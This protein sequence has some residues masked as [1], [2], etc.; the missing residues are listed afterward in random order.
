MVTRR[1][2]TSVFYSALFILLM[3]PALSFAD[4]TTTI[5]LTNLAGAARGEE[6]IPAVT[7]ASTAEITFRSTG[8]SNVKAQLSLE[9]G[10]ADSALLDISR[11]FIKAR[12][13]AFRLTLGK[14]R[15]SWGEGFM[16]NAGDVLFDSLSAAVDL[17]GDEIRT[18]GSW[19]A[20]VYLPLGRFSFL[21]TVLL[22][23]VFDPLEYLID[24]R[25]AAETGSDMP[26]I[27][28][29]Y[30]TSAGARL[31]LRPGGIKTETGY[32]YSGRTESHRPYASLQGH[33]LADW[34]LSASTDMSIYEAGTDGADNLAVSFG[35]FHS[36][37]TSPAA[38]LNLRLEGAV[39]PLADEKN[40]LL[41]PEISF[42][43]D[44]R[45]T[46]FL[47]NI[48]SIDDTSSVHIAGMTWNIYQGFKILAYGGICSGENGDTFSWDSTLSTSAVPGYFVSAGCSFVF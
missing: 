46:I 6:N 35:L 45:R 20:S 36:V 43:P 34:N 41:Y 3:L 29:G 4:S 11:A 47:R 17:T 37:K 2:N 24:S 44:D 12:F 31:V 8:N 19:L 9:A 42:S 5:E 38:A 22:P 32:L 40:L 39:N 18:D 1:E 21:E 16:F 25:V 28:G 15:L 26:E 14:T 30:R 7:A 13:P 48:F 10:I 27:P 23:P 33:L